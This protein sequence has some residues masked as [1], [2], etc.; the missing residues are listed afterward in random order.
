MLGRRWLPEAEHL[1][2]VGEERHLHVLANAERA[3]DGGDLEGAPDAFA[4]DLARREAEERLAAEQDLA[5]VGAELAVD[6]VDAG[7]LAG[8]VRSEERDELH[9]PERD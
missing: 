5:R 9:C 4:P 2:R 3:P 8:A 1:A 6:D 7:P